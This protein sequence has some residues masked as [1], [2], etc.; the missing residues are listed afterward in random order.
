MFSNQKTGKHT[1]KGVF[2]FQVENYSELAV[3]Q[4]NRYAV[5]IALTALIAVTQA[6][7]RIFTSRDSICLN[8]PDGNRRS[9]D[10]CEISTSVVPYLAEHKEGC[11]V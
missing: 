11:K 5:R 9:I 10:T 4:N 7:G 6:A 2:L 8:R 3:L 1:H